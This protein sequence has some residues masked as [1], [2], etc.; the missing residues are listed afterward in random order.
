V[1]HCQWKETAPVDSV[2]GAQ[3]KKPEK[4]LYHS[5]RVVSHDTFNKKEVMKKGKKERKIKM[6]CTVSLIT[7]LMSHSK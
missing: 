6:L 1:A 2:W 3:E 4:C 5:N 7:V